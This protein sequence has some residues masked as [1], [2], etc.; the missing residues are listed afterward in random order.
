[1]DH[2]LEY[3]ADGL[4]SF[5]EHTMSDEGDMSRS[6]N[7][8]EG[9]ERD[10]RHDE[11]NAIRQTLDE[12]GYYQEFSL[13]SEQLVRRLLDDLKALTA[14]VGR[15]GVNLDEEVRAEVARL[16]VENNQL[17][18]DLLKEMEDHDRESGRQR[19]RLRELEEELEN[20]RAL[21]D[22][23]R[24]DAQRRAETAEERAKELAARLDRALRSAEAAL[25]G[26]DDKEPSLR[27]R[28]ILSEYSD[29]A[30]MLDERI[31]L[32]ET[33]INDLDAEA[34]R[35]RGENERLTDEVSRLRSEL[36]HSNAERRLALQELETR[37]EATS[38]GNTQ[39]NRRIASLE[40]QLELLRDHVEDLEKDLTAAQTAKKALQARHE[41]Q[42]RKLTDQLKEEKSTVAD[43]K[44]DLEARQQESARRALAPKPAPQTS[45]P[46]VKAQTATALKR[47]IVPANRVS[48]SN[49]EAISAELASTKERLVSAQKELEEQNTEIKTLRRTVEGKHYAPRFFFRR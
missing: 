35:L 45:L 44:K 43:L 5:I 23:A 42:I 46:K 41:E 13:G 17:H 18:A 7:G 39:A 14:R 32:L 29:S 28:S 40:S 20:L 48:A 19:S 38:P 16:T 21:G 33:E 30:Q 31:Q 12:M 27:R 8:S 47:T 3:D 10:Q 36:D 6:S 9:R 22:D 37:K 2:S 25:E 1:M 34:E 11:G 49:E 15:P 4:D 26:E 24:Q